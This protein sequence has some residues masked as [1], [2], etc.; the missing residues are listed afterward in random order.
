[1]SYFYKYYELELK[2]HDLLKR[3]KKKDKELNKLKESNDDMEEYFIKYLKFVEKS[4]KMYEKK[5]ILRES[6]IILLLLFL[7]I[8]YYMT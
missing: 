2:Y 6:V 4:D 3:Y 7:F 1:M 8:N 5:I